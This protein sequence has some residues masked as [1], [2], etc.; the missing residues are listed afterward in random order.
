VPR[1]RELHPKR[2]TARSSV[3]QFG[4][5]LRCVQYEGCGGDRG[6]EW[7]RGRAEAG[8]PGGCVPAKAHAGGVGG[9]DGTTVLQRRGPLCPLPPPPVCAPAL[10]MVASL[11]PSPSPVRAPHTH[12]TTTST[13]TLT[14]TRPRTPHTHTHTHTFTPPPPHPPTPESWRISCASRRTR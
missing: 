3:A 14:S 12:M 8:L 7:G 9:Y 13:N 5:A 10:H 6:N 11:P 1:D 2:G 4:C